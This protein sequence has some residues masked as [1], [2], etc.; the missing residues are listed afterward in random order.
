MFAWDF[1]AGGSRQS[2]IEFGPPED[3]ERRR[4]RVCCPPLVPCTKFTD[5]PG[6][7]RLKRIVRCEVVPS[8]DQVRQT[9]VEPREITVERR[10]SQAVERECL[11]ALEHE[12]RVQATRAFD[13]VVDPSWI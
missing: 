3:R 9:L 13:A 1:A 5:L 4:Y 6:D 11:A 12:Y 8:L 7:F 2:A 10:R